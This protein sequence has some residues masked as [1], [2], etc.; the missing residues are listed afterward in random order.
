MARFLDDA[1]EVAF[2]IP[3]AYNARMGLDRSGLPFI[4]GALLLTAIVWMTMG[5]RWSLP[6]LVAAGFFAFFFRDPPRTVPPTD[7]SMVIAPADGRVLVAGE[8]QEGVAPAG[9]W[10][11]ISIFLSPLDVHVNRVPVSGRVLRVEQSHGQSLPAY[12]QEAAS[13]NSRSE[14]WMDADGRVVVF[15]QVVGIVARRIVCRLQPGQIVQAGDRFGIMKFGSRM[16]VF[17]PPDATLRVSKGDKVR[18]GETILA[19]LS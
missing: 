5:L 16:D 17:L 10:R 6:F 14:I 3:K 15:R 18:S 9:T 7:R 8:G 4:V 2:T 13:A 1:L 12:R 19:R 11:Q